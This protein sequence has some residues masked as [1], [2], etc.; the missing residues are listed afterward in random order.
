M[1]L[2]EV[3]VWVDVLPLREDWQLLCEDPYTTAEISACVI[4]VD[5]KLTSAEEA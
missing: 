3:S 2:Q 5:T 4:S 1:A